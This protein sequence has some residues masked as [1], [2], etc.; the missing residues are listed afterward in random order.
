VGPPGEGT[1]PAECRLAGV[2][3]DQASKLI[4]RFAFVDLC[5]LQLY[6]AAVGISK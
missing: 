2:Q 5:P 1:D 6:Q 3:H 4:A